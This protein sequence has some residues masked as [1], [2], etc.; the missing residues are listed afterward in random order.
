MPVG[1]EDDSVA[2]I[3]GERE[4]FSEGTCVRLFSGTVE[5]WE[6]GLSD[7]VCVGVFDT[8]IDGD[9]EG[10]SEGNRDWVLEGLV[11]GL[12]VAEL[13]LGE[14]DVWISGY[15]VASEDGLNVCARDAD[16]LG[17]A[18]GEGDH[19]G[20]R[21]STGAVVGS[22]APSEVLQSKLSRFRPPFLAGS[23]KKPNRLHGSSES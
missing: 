5:G 20:T 22:K 9:V 21:K 3:E 2:D 14:R 13:K 17:D 16:A 4:G 8:P 11:V 18:E 15:A 23:L 10:A 12:W 1:A 19:K 7:G 6:D